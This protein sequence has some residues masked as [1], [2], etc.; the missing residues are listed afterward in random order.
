MNGNIEVEAG[1]SFDSGQKYV[2]GGVAKVIKRAYVDFGAMPATALK[3]VAHGLSLDPAYAKVELIANDGTTSKVWTKNEVTVDA[4]N[5]SVTT[6][7]SEVAF[8]AIAVIDYIE[9]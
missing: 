1:T 3:N 5:V 8:T 7:A 9:A 4:T 2:S 6:T